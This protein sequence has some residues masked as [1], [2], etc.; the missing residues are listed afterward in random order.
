MPFAEA[1]AAFMKLRTGVS[2]STAGRVRKWSAGTIQR[3]E[4]YGEAFGATFGRVPLIELTDGHLGA[5]AEERAAAGV[6]Q[7]VVRKETDMAVRVLRD[8]GLWEKTG[9]LF[10]AY[11]RQ[12]LPMVESDDQRALDRKQIKA[13]MRVLAQKSEDSLWVLYDSVVALYTCSSTNER[14]LA[15]IED[16]MLAQRL[17]HVGPRQSKNK[18]RNRWIPLEMDEVLFAFEWLLERAA[19]KGATEPHHYLYPWRSKRG[20]WDPTRPMTRWCLSQ[21]F[22]GVGEAIGVDDLR[23]YD[24]RHAAMSLLAC[25][26]TPIDVILAFGG[27]VSEKMRKHY[28]TVSMMAKRETQ[29]AAWKNFRLLEDGP[30]G[31]ELPPKR[32]P[33]SVKP[34][35]SIAACR[36]RT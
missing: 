10:R 5:Y 32:G 27:Q 9:E 20:E 14:R 18:Y 3:Y 7:N 12:R 29:P 33:I 24:L 1:F 16:V 11:E 35:R 28:T 8:A 17:F 22:E 30:P 25:A 4:E 21:Q 6:S 13:L 26:G 34:P 2:E 31:P 36:R 19:E 23:P 15:K